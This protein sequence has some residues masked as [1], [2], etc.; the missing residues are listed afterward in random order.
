MD[1]KNQKNKGFNNIF[2]AFAFI[3]QM[4]LSFAIPIFLGVLAGNWLDERLGTGFIFLILLFLLGIA[5]GAL[6]AYHLYQ[7]IFMKK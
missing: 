2:E 4:A 6:G 3:P 7:S 5:G 1:K